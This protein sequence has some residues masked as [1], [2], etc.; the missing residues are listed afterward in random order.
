MCCRHAV[1]R[2]FAEL[3]A[4]GVPE[5]HAVEAALVIHRAHHPDTPIN[6]AVAEVT[7]WTLGRL[8]H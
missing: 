3:T 4:R 2:A 1:E 7:R 6:M 5:K 8:L